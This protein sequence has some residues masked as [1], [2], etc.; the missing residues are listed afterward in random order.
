MR[1]IPWHGVGLMFHT[2]LPDF[3]RD[4]RDAFDYLEIMPDTHWVETVEDGASVYVDAPDSIA[5]LDRLRADG[6]P[7]VLHSIGLSIASADHFDHRHLAHIAGGADLTGAAG[8]PGQD[9]R[10]AG[11]GLSARRAPWAGRGE[12]LEG[13]T[14]AAPDLQAVRGG[15]QSAPRSSSI[16]S[17]G[18]ARTVTSP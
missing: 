13:G 9:S 5:Y 10:R 7:M 8:A 12:Q 2:A 18:S 6:V 17:N 3:V 11:P 14:P 4:H 1:S 16:A 15:D